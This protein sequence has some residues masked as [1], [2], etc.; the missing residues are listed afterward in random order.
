MEFRQIEYF[1]E[2]AR[3]PSL[4]KAAEGLYISQQALSRSIQSL[5]EEL[6]CPLLRR[7]S[8]GSELTE[9][10]KYLRDAFQPIVESYRKAEED[11]LDH[12][13]KRPLKVSFASAPLVFGVLDTSL[14]TDFKSEYPA[15]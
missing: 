13:S 9:E 15:V 10:G 8:K 4:S 1:L 3:H 12:L 5:E 2:A 14:L 7:T 6:G 11:A